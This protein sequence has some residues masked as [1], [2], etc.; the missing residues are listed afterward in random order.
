M[1]IAIDGP[2]SSGKSTVAKLLAQDF[3]YIFVDTGAMYRAVTLALL[4]AKVD[5]TNLNQVIETLNRCQLDFKFVAVEGQ[6]IQH[7]FLNGQDVERR[8]RSSKV[9]DNV[10]E[11]SAIPI[12]RQVLVDR[13]REIAEEKSV[14]MEG[15]DIGTVVLPQA[16]YKFFFTARPEVRAQRRYKEN[17]ERGLA[18]E[19]YEEILAS[20]IA[21]DKYDSSRKH[22]PLKKAEDA[23]EIDASDLT[24]EEM[25]TY[26][27]KII[28]K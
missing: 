14:V 11:V 4:D 19:S 20:I 13:Q 28:T 5:F 1:Q 7:I 15:R 18:T 3:N 12:V 8:V 6:K 10:S 2:A 9:T 27:K 26:V 17:V 25:L 22:S 16:D 23:I 24:I 21:R